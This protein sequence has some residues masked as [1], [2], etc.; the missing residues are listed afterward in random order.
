MEINELQCALEAVLFAAGEPVDTD[1]L[2]AVLEVPEETLHQAARV[3]AGEYDYM[4]R[5]IKLVRLEDRYQLCSRADYAP[6]VRRA[7]ETRRAPSLSSAALEVLAIAAYRQPVTKVY[8]EQVRGVDSSYTIRSL[9]EKGLLE[10]CGRLDVPGRPVLFRTTGDFLR[11]FGLS[12][13]TELPEI[14]GLEDERMEQL[15][16]PMMEEEKQETEKAEAA[17]K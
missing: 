13:L 3:L 11:S 14:E 15:T 6:W 9:C 5:G 4:R 10:E 17:E 16:L 1:K 2:C 12:S 7:L 8:I